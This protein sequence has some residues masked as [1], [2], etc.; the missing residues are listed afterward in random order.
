M[1]TIRVFPCPLGLTYELRAEPAV[2]S[3]N[4]RAGWNHGSHFPGGASGFWLQLAPGQRSAVGAG[5]AGVGRPSQS[6]WT[7]V[8][9]GP[10]GVSRGQT[11]SSNSELACLCGFKPVL[12]LFEDSFLSV[13]IYNSVKTPGQLVMHFEVC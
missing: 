4:P 13:N 9:C 12:M 6:V 8:K 7:L 5:S 1:K 10:R 11:N 2:S 3:S